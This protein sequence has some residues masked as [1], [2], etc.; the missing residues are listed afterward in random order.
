MESNHLPIEFQ[1]NINAVTHQIYYSNSRWKTKE[2]KWEL[3]KESIQQ[4]LA[5]MQ[6]DLRTEDAYNFLINAVNDAAV[7]SIPR[8]K[9]F[10]V[11]KQR[12]PPWWTPE[13]SREVA[14]RRLALKS[15]RP[16]STLDN[17][18]N[19]Q[20]VTAHTKKFLKKVKKD[21]WIKYCSSLNK[22]NSMSSI[23]HKTRAFRINRQPPPPPGTNAWLEEFIDRLAPPTVPLL[24]HPLP[25]VEDQHHMLLSPFSKEEINEAINSSN[26]SCPG[27]DYISYSMLANLP[28]EAKN[29]LLDIFNQY[30]MQKDLIATWKTQVI[31]PILKSGKDPH[32]A[33]NYRPIALSSCVAKTLE[34]MIKRGD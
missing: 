11:M 33:S 13:C 10:T 6:G 32:V 14:K 26:Y 19:L 25:V 27:I 31:I 9:E 23:W 16:N 29:L 20:K 4:T 28:T 12:F 15:Y 18:I 3:Y 7:V 17:F 24:N 1:I 34:R 21:G 22:E 8:K 5:N 2:A 30:W